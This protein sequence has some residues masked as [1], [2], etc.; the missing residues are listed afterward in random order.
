MLDCVKL[1]S[2]ITLLVKE[3]ETIV[4]LYVAKIRLAIEANQAKSP[5]M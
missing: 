5:S 1:S 3:H 4:Q 2:Y